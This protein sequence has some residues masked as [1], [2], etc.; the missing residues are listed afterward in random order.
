MF[1]IINLTILTKAKCSPYLTII[2]LFEVEIPTYNHTFSVP[3]FTEDLDF[4]QI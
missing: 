1:K 2:N 4:N 3:L